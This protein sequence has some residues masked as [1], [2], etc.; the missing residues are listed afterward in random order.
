VSDTGG[1]PMNVPS[2]GREH[3]PYLIHLLAALMG[4]IGACSHAQGQVITDPSVT[5]GATR[6]FSYSVSYL[7]AEDTSGRTVPLQEPV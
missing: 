1:N 3:P 2:A 4:L 7:V 6:H 5:A